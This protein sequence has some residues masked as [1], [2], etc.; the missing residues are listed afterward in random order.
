MSCI[1][2]GKTTSDIKSFTHLDNEFAL[3]YWSTVINIKIALSRQIISFNRSNQNF[4]L[5]RN[6]NTNARSTAHFT[7][8]S[9]LVYI[10]TYINACLSLCFLHLKT[11]VKSDEI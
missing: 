9:A 5:V 1:H 3:K 7:Y 8:K 4:V 10:N 2:L 11:Y 6:I